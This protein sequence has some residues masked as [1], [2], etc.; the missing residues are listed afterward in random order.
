MERLHLLLRR[1]AAKTRKPPV[2][3]A[4]ENNLRRRL[5]PRLS[6]LHV[7]EKYTGSPFALP[8]RA[9]RTKILVKSKVSGGVGVGTQTVAAGRREKPNPVSTGTDAARLT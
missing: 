5:T 4:A 2:V 8:R 9:F 1:A 7:G 6:F 3:D